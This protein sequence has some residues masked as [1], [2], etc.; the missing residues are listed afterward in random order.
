MTRLFAMMM[1]GVLIAPLITPALGNESIT[2]LGNARES[3]GMDWEAL[4]SAEFNKVP[5]LKFDIGAR[6]PTG[7]LP[8]GPKLDTLEPF[9]LQPA[10]SGTQFSSSWKFVP[11]TTTE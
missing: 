10:G 9:L 3:R 6:V 4:L 7:E 1:A 5:W 2:K 11:Q 8:I